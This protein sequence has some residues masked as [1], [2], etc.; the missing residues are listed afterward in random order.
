MRGG[1]PSQDVWPVAGYA[2]DSLNSVLFRLSSRLDGPDD[3]H[4]ILHVGISDI[5][6]MHEAVAW[7]EILH[8]KPDVAGGGVAGLKVYQTRLNGAIET[9]HF[10]KRLFVK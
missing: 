9:P 2:V 7:D 5:S 4:E 3:Y 1:T 10:R 6:R 8:M